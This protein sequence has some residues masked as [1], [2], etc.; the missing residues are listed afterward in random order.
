MLAELTDNYK[1]IGLSNGASLL[2]AKFLFRPKGTQQIQGF[3]E[4]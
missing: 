1:K 4:I 2:S 3:Q